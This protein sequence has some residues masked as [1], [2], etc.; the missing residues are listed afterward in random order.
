LPELD[1]T[2][3]SS[4]IASHRYSPA[5]PIGMLSMN[6]MDWYCSEPRLALNR[7]IVL[8]YRLQLEAKKLA[9][10]TNQRPA[11]CRAPP[12][13]RGGRYRL[14]EARTGCR[15]PASER[16]TTIGRRDG[17]WLS[18]QGANSSPWEPL[19]KHFGRSA[20]AAIIS[21]LLDCG[22]RRSEVVALRFGDIQKREDHWAIVDLVGKAGH[23][24]TVPVPAWVKDVVD[25][26]TENASIPN[27][28]LF[29]S[30]RKNGT[31]WGDGITQNGLRG[32][33][34]N[35]QIGTPRPEV[36]LCEIVPRCGRRIGA[37]PIPAGTRV[38][39][40][41]RAIHRVQTGTEPGGQRSAP[42]RGQAGLMPR[43]ACR[44]R[45]GDLATVMASNSG[46]SLSSL[47]YCMGERGGKS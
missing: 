21:L 36:D 18:L 20:R 32:P 29:R 7:T 46:V 11:S 39:P 43:Y 31:V 22:L 3:R 23:V 8:R 27:G 40:D 12:G 44:H 14:A 47:R 19:L 35:Q 15:H 26:W 34:R 6:S 4:S 37:D 2:N 28:R 33:R 42:L 45:E 25:R 5:D 13:I 17:N 1:Q 16:S 24:R 10:S 41:D 38:R 9:A 30:I